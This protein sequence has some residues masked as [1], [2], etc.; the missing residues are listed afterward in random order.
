MPPCDIHPGKPNNKGYVSRWFEGRLRGVHEI[1][2]IEANGPIPAGYE[3]DHT[4]GNRACRELTHLRLLTHRANL[5]A[6]SN[7][8]PGINARKTHCVNG[9]PFD[10]ENTYTT[11]Q[12]KRHCRACNRDKAR[13]RYQQRTT[14]S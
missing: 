6:S 14:R 4:C 1:A 5:L 12:G 11:K 3:I 8:L 2:W 13:E 9:H 7:T 10:A